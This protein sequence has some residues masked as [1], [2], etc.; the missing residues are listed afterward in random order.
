MISGRVQG[1]GFRYW[2]AGEA[3]RAGVRGWARNTVDGSVEA[4]I[5]GDDEAVEAVVAHCRAEPPAARVTGVAREPA[6]DPGGEGFRILPE[7]R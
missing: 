7:A 5:A 4:V 2:L 3:R 1:V 6:P